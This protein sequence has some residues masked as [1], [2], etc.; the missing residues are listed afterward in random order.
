M[1]TREY[2]LRELEIARS[3]ND[4]RRVMPV[5]LPKRRRILD[6]G[7]G[8][9]QTLI[10]SELAP[11]V[12]AV[13]IDIDQDA[14]ALGKE[15]SSDV[16]F[17]AG[18]A[19]SLPFAGAA[20][21]LVIARVALPLTYAPAAVAEMRR[22]LVP[23]GDVWLALHSLRDTLHLLSENLR[24]LELKRAAYRTYVLA[25]G[26]LY[27]LTGWMAPFPSRGRYETFQTNQSIERELH[28]AGFGAIQTTHGDHYV[29]T[30]TKDPS[31]DDRLRRSLRQ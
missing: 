21:D 15:L 29:V 2:H 23:G 6:V 4:P 18:R 30:A 26:L 5:I 9:G 8:A 25:N 28:R 3:P 27:H 19:E 13:G 17:V 7:C 10:A 31:M 24:R 1:S 14:L 16:H 22:V 11:G 12:L 20:F